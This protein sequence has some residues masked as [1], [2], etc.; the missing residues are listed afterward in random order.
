MEQNASV[1]QKAAC[2][3]C[4]DGYTRGCGMLERFAE[5]ERNVRAGAAGWNGA[6]VEDTVRFLGSKFNEAFEELSSE[7]RD[8]YMR[9]TGRSSPCTE[10]EGGCTQLVW[11]ASIMISREAAR[12]EGR[13][14]ELFVRG[15]R[16]VSEEMNRIGVLGEW[17][18]VWGR[19]L[20]VVAV[21]MIRASMFFSY[22]QYRGAHSVRRRDECETVDGEEMEE[23]EESRLHV[24][25]G[26]TL[27]R[28]FVERKTR[29]YG[30]FW[31]TE[32][33]RERRLGMRG[34]L[35]KSER[36]VRVMNEMVPMVCFVDKRK[37]T[38]KR[39]QERWREAFDVERNGER[40]K[41]EEKGRK[42]SKEEEGGE[43]ST[44][45][46]RKRKF[47]EV[48]G[49]G[50][51][52]EAR[53][54][55][56]EDLFHELVAEVVER[57]G[58]GAEELLEVAKNEIGCFAVEHRKAEVF[59][60]S[61]SRKRDETNAGRRVEGGQRSEGRAV[62]GSVHAETSIGRVWEGVRRADHA[63]WERAWEELHG[64]G[65]RRYEEGF[66]MSWKL[67]RRVEEECLFGMEM[68]RVLSGRRWGRFREVARTYFLTGL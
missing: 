13:E 34:I 4:T 18:P 37:G 1:F 19:M 54:E 61:I 11:T 27:V 30:R 29:E 15:V 45:K 49:L 60:E 26:C 28:K 53:S 8:E 42:K 36:L 64:G 25:L 44:V 12:V 32:V 58:M 65:G 20:P 14:A 22:E 33:S 48:A 57:C 67:E 63:M 66:T 17:L 5:V 38:D 55:K 6:R 51:S 43:G 50:G 56:G 39:I 9:E 59:G 40:E 2:R 31:K 3:L 7:E 24:D 35:E 62:W 21:T 47:D 23:L 68:V 46:N 10:L 41:N 16:M 52:G